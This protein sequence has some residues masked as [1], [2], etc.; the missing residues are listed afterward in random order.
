MTLVDRF[1]PSITSVFRLGR[2]RSQFAPV[3]TWH[4]EAIIRQIGGGERDKPSKQ[5]KQVQR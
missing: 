4:D 5:C 1:A 3:R 2:T